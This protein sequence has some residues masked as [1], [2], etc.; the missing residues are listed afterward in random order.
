MAMVVTSPR[1]LWSTVWQ[2]VWNQRLF[3]RGSVPSRKT[4][5]LHTCS[6]RESDQA[7]AQPL[8]CMSTPAAWSQSKHPRCSS[9]HAA[10]NN[11]SDAQDPA[12]R[13]TGKQSYSAPRACYREME[14][15]LERA[16]ELL[17]T[18]RQKRLVWRRAGC[19]PA[20]ATHRAGGRSSTATGIAKKVQTHKH[21]LSLIHI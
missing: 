17:A 1:L 10:P 2:V 7:H 11:P 18:V 8:C 13:A 21:C 14:L 4:R 6:E 16:T 3:H 20:V 19:K 9:T 12:P 15:P 5:S